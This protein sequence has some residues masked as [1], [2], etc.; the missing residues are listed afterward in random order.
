MITL[1]W[2]A[3]TRASRIVWLL[4]ELAIPYHL[5]VVDVRSADAKG[6]PHFRAASPMG[7]VPAISDGEVKLADSAAIALYLADRY[8]QAHLAP[9]ITDPL[10]GKYCYWMT[11]TPGVIEP[12]MMERFNGWTVS[13]GTCGWGNFDLM[14]ATL[15]AGL[16]GNEWILG[17]RFTAAD[18]LLGSSVYFMRLFGILPESPVLHGYVDRCLSRPAYARA[19]ERDAAPT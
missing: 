11:F 19:L 14:V 12:A 15:Q 8:P 1:Y 9:A 6:D 4:E 5:E 17:E 7:K 13:P 2:C 3:Q 10:R 16:E 18:V